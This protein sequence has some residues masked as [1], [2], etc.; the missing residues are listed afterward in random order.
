[1]EECRTAGQNSKDVLNCRRLIINSLELFELSMVE[2][3]ED[4]EN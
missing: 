1:M 4:D 2:G 3:R